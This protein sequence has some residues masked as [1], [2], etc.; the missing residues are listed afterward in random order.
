[1]RRLILSLLLLFPAGCV[2]DE[3]GRRPLPAQPASIQPTA[4]GVWATPPRDS[5]SNGFLDSVDITVYVSS[6][7]FPA[8][9]HVPGRFTFRLIGSD[10]SELAKWEYDEPATTAAMRRNAVGPGYFFRLNVKDVAK[11][12]FEAQST[13]LAAEFTPRAGSPV[14]APQTGLRFGRVRP[15][16]QPGRK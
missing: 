2:S 13:D 16:V 15:V 9:V 1:M 4:V 8:P 14:S 11:D 12:E 6:D 7:Q 10:K 3:P 5:D